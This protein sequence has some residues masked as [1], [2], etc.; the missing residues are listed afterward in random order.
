MKDLT[1]TLPNWSRGDGRWFSLVVALGLASRLVF[2]YLHPTLAFWGDDMVHY[3]HLAKM[4][5]F[6][7][8]Y[9]YWGATPDAF[10]TP[11]FPLFLAACYWVA[12][13][14]SASPVAWLR[15]TYLVQGLLSGLECGLMYMSA[16]FA[17][18]RWA[19]LVTAAL[20][21]IY[22]PAV[23]T[24][25]VPL[26]EALFVF[27]LMA[28][29]TSW[30][31]SMTRPSAW[32]WTVTGILLALAT[33]VR[34]V[35]LP[36]IVA[37]LLT[38]GL[39]R[40]PAH[41]DNGAERRRLY[42]WR[43]GLMAWHAAGFLVCMLPWWIRNARVLHRL[44]LTDDDSANPLLYGSFPN[45][46]VPPGFHPGPDQ[47]AQAIERI[48]WGFT[49]QPWEYLRWY[50]IGKIKYLFGQPWMLTGGPAWLWHSQAVLHLALLIAGTLG[51]L[52]A[53]RRLYARVWLF[54]AAFLIAVLLPFLP[55]PRYAF[56]TMLF[57]VLG[58]GLFLERAAEVLSRYP[59]STAAQTEATA[60]KH[61]GDG[62]R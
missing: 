45:M 52:T 61:I 3:D 14:F 29:T 17:L 8:V 47:K 59:A 62:G 32:S 36:L 11:G 39:L 51:L 13:H 2:V 22:Y 54:M 4:V 57:F 27:F 26:T 56:P 15:F 46:Q 48:V 33:L 28:F 30:L 53:W 40:H 6:H 55:L 60:G 5:L 35:T 38:A 12:S 24:A 10:V 31:F 25:S 49:H 19:A 21:L 43:L 20:W 34:P 58:T 23:W 41:R 1:R 44:L 18:T 42:G 9:S 16:R 7:H 37:T 50:T